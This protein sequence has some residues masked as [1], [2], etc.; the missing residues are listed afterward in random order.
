ME[1]HSEMD[2][3]QP[4]FAL[5]QFASLFARDL[6]DLVDEPLLELKVSNNSD[7][8]ALGR[9]AVELKLAGKRLGYGLTDWMTVEPGTVVWQIKTCSMRV[10]PALPLSTSCYGL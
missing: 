5:L 6:G 1:V 4:S 10:P 9:F 3:D 8:P 2:F 7:L